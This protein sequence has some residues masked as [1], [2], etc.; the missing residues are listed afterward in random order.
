[1]A[2]LHRGPTARLHDDVF[3]L[4]VETRDYLTENRMRHIPDPTWVSVAESM[5]L[6]TRIIDMM[7][8]VLA[9]KAVEHGEIDLDTCRQK[10]ALGAMPVHL[11]PVNDTDRGRLPHGLTALLD[12]SLGLYQRIARLDGNDMVQR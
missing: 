4:L 2:V 7:A 12:R 6:T 1:M 8:W 3:A 10:Y 5:R 11:V 9:H